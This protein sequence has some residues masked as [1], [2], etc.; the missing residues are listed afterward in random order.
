MK[1]W[2]LDTEF[3]HGL[4]QKE[5]QLGK[6][7]LSSIKTWKGNSQQSKLGKVILS[8]IR[9]WKGNSRFNQNLER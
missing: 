3:E 7:I 2:N 4:L 8:S 1:Q 9:T 5:F 6:V